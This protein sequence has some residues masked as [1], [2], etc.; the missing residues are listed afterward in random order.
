MKWRT[1]NFVDFAEVQPSVPLER[2]QE[3]PFISMEIIEPHRRAVQPV[4]S[5]VWDGGGGARFQNGD[6]IF[7]RITPCL[8]H[9]KTAKIEGLEKAAFGS[10]EFFVFRARPDVSDADFIYYLACSKIIREPAI[11][12]MIGASGRQRAQRT[13]IE[14]LSIRVPATIEAQRKIASILSAY[15]DLIENNSRRIKLLEE[16]ARLLYQE[17]FVRLRFPGHEHTHIVD[18]VPKGWEKGKVCDIGKVITGK[19][20]STKEA[21][22]Y[23]GNIPF[24]KTPDMHK[25][26][27]VVSTEQ[28]LSEKGANTQANKYIPEGSIMVSCIG[29]VGV[30]AFNG[31]SAQTNQQINTVI[32]KK[33]EFRHYAFFALCDIKPRLEALG[34]GATM[35]NVNKS[36][37]ES[38]PLLIPH[39]TLLR[40]YD[41]ISSPLFEQ[42]RMLILINNSLRS[43]RDLLLPR[44]MD[45][46]LAV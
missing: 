16:S 19:T 44:L 23:G 24:I 46:R 17:W 7:A 42:M 31:L 5:R 34:G 25:N 9:G 22:N 37:F 10:T 30:V 29:T 26:P 8:E 3:Y 40:N 6:T 28:Y 20:P 38:I 39:M 2:G 21:D 27:I 41:E 15:D 12:S 4:E 32:P 43:A 35:S 45:G 14:G 13:V 1:L 33:P 11:K 18:R 36:K